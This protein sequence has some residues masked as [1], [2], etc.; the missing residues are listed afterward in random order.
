MEKESDN[1]EIK[2]Y[3]E[4]FFNT[5][6]AELEEKE[7]ILIVKEVPET[8]EKT[9][10]KK[11]PY[12]FSFKQQKEGTEHVTKGG[13]LL[14]AI[15]RYLEQIGTT[16]LLKIDFD[17]TLEREIPRLIQ[18]RNTSIQNIQKKYRHN[19]FSRF[20]FQTT[21]SYLNETETTINEVYVHEGKIIKGNL[22]GYKIIEGEKEEAS[23]KKL[24]E[25]Y[26][27]AKKELQQLLKEKKESLGTTISK[28]LNEEI[29]R[30]QEHYQA[31]I[32]ELGT[33]LQTLLNKINT[34]EKELL[35]EKEK[36]VIIQKEKRLE[37]LQKILIKKGDDKQKE[38]I[39]REEETTIKD[40][41]EKYSLKIQNKLINTTIIYYPIYDFTMTVTLE[42]Q[43]KKRI[44][45]SY[46]PLTK[47]LDDFNCETCNKKI[48]FIH[49]C[50]NGHITCNDCISVCQNCN[51][52]YC[53][54]CLTEKC[55][56]T[57][58]KT[59]KKCLVTCRGCGKKTSTK[60]MKKDFLTG[61]ERCTN[62]LTQCSE[63]KGLVLE[64]NIAQKEKKICY[65][66][67]GKQKQKQALK[68]LFKR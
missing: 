63:C 41:K 67:T 58:Q 6:K 11:A 56:I 38:N 50:T 27:V 26:E 54:D 37:Q 51:N 2:K 60:N 61:E 12:N 28:T 64:K 57:K 8:F 59:C 44:Q 34:L 33:E 45:K 24:K 7:E 36:D 19:F 40:T 14:K 30:I 53:D 5:I 16:T 10:G 21:F 15:A 29:T 25:D 20:S 68:G 52:S 62:C 22:E 23:T 31:Q 55:N 39:I 32:Q 13:T 1:K 3:V 46:D 18:L 47:T 48:Q 35:E 42:N 66:C 17:I 49:L 9:Y 65:K 4:Q 43:N